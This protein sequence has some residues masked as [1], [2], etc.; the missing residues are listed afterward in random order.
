M[1]KS[2]KLRKKKK[3]IEYS[4]YQASSPTYDSPLFKLKFYIVQ[5]IHSSFLVYSFSNC[6]KYNFY[7]H[8]RW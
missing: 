4:F 1:L 2:L 3:K 6:L 8:I 5:F 7:I